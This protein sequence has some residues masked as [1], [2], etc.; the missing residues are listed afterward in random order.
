[1]TVVSSH[2]DWDPLEECF[3]GIADHARIPTVDKSTHSFGFADCK[4]EHIK[5]LEGAIC[6]INPTFEFMK[7]M[8]EPFSKLLG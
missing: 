6:C 3:V 4:Y 5:D 8:P 1:M 7:F 2:N